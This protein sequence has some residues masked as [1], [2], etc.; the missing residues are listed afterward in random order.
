MCGR[1]M[2]WIVANKIVRVIDLVY[3][4]YLHVVG[5]F[6]KSAYIGPSAAM[7]QPKKYFDSNLM[8]QMSGF[9]Q[10]AVCVGEIVRLKV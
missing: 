6:W 5:K 3:Y 8:I 2:S 1:S 10:S 9:Y 7:F 4:F